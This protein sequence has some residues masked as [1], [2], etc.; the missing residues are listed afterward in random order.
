M[1]W[2]TWEKWIISEKHS[3][4]KLNQKESENVKRLIATNEIEAVIGKLPANKSPEPD[5]IIGEI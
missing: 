4:P 3:L 2:T 5:D 1:N